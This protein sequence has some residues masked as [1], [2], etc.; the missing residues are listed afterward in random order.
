MPGTRWP[1]TRRAGRRRERAPAR[2]PARDPRAAP[3]SGRVGLQACARAA[4]SPRST[5]R[6]PR[7]SVRCPPRAS[8]AP[9]ARIHRR[10]LTANFKTYSEILL[11]EK[12]TR[13]VP[14]SLIGDVRTPSPHPPRL[15]LCA[16]RRLR[17]GRRTGCVGQRRDPGSPRSD[18]RGTGT[19]D[20]AND[21]ANPSSTGRSGSSIARSTG[22]ADRRNAACHAR[23]RTG[24]WDYH[25][26][27]GAS[28]TLAAG[29]ADE[30]GFKW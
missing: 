1:V 13:W 17:A 22:D 8:P 26:G 23:S 12:Q 28:C 3:V 19:P 7:P 24:S 4:G 10:D 15:L 29:L 11:D 20:T 9:P 6:G 27:S 14:I 25:T 16:G 2:P 18:R 30:H 5:V 21:R